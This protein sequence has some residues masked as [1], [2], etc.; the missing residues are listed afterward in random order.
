M[1]LFT[2][3]FY[4]VFIEL[5]EYYVPPCDGLLLC[6]AEDVEVICEDGDPACLGFL[7]EYGGYHFF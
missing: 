7:S 5:A 4:V 3:E 1:S 6:V 2:G